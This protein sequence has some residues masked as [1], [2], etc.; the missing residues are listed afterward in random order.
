MKKRLLL[1][2]LAGFA[3]SSSYAQSSAVQFWDTTGTAKTAK[4]GWSG[5]S[6]T[7]EFFIETPGSKTVAVKDGNVSVPGSVTATKFVGDGSGL[8]NLPISTIVGPTGPQ[9]PVGA[10]GLTGATGPA[11]PKGDTGV[12][13]PRGPIGLTGATGAA[14]AQGPIGPAGAA[15]GITRYASSEGCG[16]TCPSL[17]PTANMMTPQTINSVSITVPS[18]GTVLVYITGIVECGVQTETIYI[19]GGL[20]NSATGTPISVST[21]GWSWR[22]SNNLSG[23]SFEAQPVNVH[24]SFSVGAGTHTFYFRAMLFQGAE[25]TASFYNCNMDA[26]FIPAP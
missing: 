8:T 2:I 13:G 7:G 15:G 18:A 23:R 21:G 6:T 5:S 1:T 22:Q 3:I 9:G 20:L 17:T 16:T 26:I 14:G 25:A 24:R 19:V 10:T 11:G 4:M 12:A